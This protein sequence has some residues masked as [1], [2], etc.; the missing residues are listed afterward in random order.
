MKSNQMK[1]NEVGL[2]YRPLYTYR[3]NSISLIIDGE[4]ECCERTSEIVRGRKEEKEIN[5]ILFCKDES[6][7]AVYTIN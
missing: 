6:V 5:L 3:F 4:Y 2:I 1:S 7:S